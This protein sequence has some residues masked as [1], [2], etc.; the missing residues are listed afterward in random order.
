ME[1]LETYGKKEC[2]MDKEN[3]SK[4]VFYLESA[5]KKAWKEF[6]RCKKMLIPTEGFQNKPFEGLRKEKKEG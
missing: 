1:Q 2:F 4:R 6:N 5:L 3:V